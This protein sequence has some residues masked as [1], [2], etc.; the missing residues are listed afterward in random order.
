LR[1]MQM[2]VTL[3]VDEWHLC[4]SIVPEIRSFLVTVCMLLMK[5]TCI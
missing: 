2:G 1:E 3:H 4:S 5:S